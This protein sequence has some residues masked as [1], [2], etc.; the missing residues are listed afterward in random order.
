VFLLAWREGRAVGCG[1]L[2]PLTA[3]IGEIKRMYAA[4][5]RAGIGGAIL[6]RLKAEAVSRGYRRLWLETRWANAAAIAFYRRA[7][8]RERANYGAYV[9][10]SECAC[11]EFD[12]RLA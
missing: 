12:L 2:R 3:G 7:G 5:P 8:F 10:R 6:D 1:A 4:E 11:F 9:G